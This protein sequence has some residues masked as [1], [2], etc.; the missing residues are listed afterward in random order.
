MKK[1]IITGLLVSLVLTGCTLGK[2]G[3]KA[4]KPDEAKTKSL[5]F[6]QKNL[7]SPGTSVEVSEITLEGDLYKLKVNLKNGDQTQEVESYMS[8]DGTKF[9]PQ[10]LDVEKIEK[11][12]ATAGGEETANQTGGQTIPKSDKPVVEIFVMSYCPYGTQIEKGILPVVEK[13]GNKIDFQLKFCSY[14]MHGAEE[15]EEN[16][17]QYCINTEQSDKFSA[18]LNCFL[19]DGDSAKCLGQ[20]GVDSQKLSACVSATNA[21][22]KIDSNSTD[23]SIYKADNEKY[24]VSGSPTL[25]INGVTADSQRDSASLLK[26]ICSAFN[27]QPEECQAQLSATAPSSGFGGGSD[28]SGANASCN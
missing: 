27:N 26:T 10:V 22:Y 2:S 15:V 9:F 18:Y 19:A 13:L 23:Y 5:E 7:V 3:A 25:V 24:G 14:T 20:T 28:S 17:R 16:T 4:L 12:S 21:K 8:K 6:I 1:I 11:E